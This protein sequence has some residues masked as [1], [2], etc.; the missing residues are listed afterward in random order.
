MP[1]RSSAT[2]WACSPIVCQAKL[3]CRQS[4]PCLVQVQGR[5]EA[6]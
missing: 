3:Q 5:A 4:L 1:G 6:E 2:G